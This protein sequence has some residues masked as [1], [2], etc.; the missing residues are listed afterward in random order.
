MGNAIVVP[1]TQRSH[2]G[3]P[4]TNIIRLSDRIARLEAQRRNPTPD[5]RRLAEA[6]AR[7]VAAVDGIHDLEDVLT[8]RAAIEAARRSYRP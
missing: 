1:E 6:S 4:M 3:L 2:G 5:R 8:F 7:L